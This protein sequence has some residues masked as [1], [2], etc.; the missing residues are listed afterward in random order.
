MCCEVKVVQPIIGIPCEG[1]NKGVWGGGGMML[2]GFPSFKLSTT[3]IDDKC[4]SE[5]VSPETFSMTSSISLPSLPENHDNSDS[6]DM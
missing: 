1:D 4:P 3:V 6:R 2:P 5:N